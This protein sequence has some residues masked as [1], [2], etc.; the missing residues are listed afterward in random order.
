VSIRRRLSLAVAL[1][2]PLAFGVTCVAPSAHAD[3]TS[4]GTS[5]HKS[6]KPHHASSGTHK[7]KGH[8]K[9]TSNS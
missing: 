1:V 2:L 4:S 7:G 9:P 3:T 8:K 6:S 5:H